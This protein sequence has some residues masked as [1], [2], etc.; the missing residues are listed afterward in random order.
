M[1]K[2][3]YTLTK[4]GIVYGNLVICAAGFFLASKG[5]INFWLLF[6]VIFGTALVIASGCVFNNLTDREIDTLMSRTRHRALVNKT[7][8]TQAA[9]FFGSCLGIIGFLTLIL[10]T[11]LL[12]VGVGLF[13]FLFYVVV[14]RIWKR[15]SVYGTLIGSVSGATP[16]V[17]GYLAVTNQLDIAALLL[18][19]ILV[20]WQMPHFFAI[21]IYR[22]DDYR[23]A[24][25][26]VLPAISGIFATKIQI[27]FF[28]VA[29]CASLPLLT[30]LGYTGYTYLIVTTIVSTAWLRLSIQ[31]FQTKNDKSWARKTFLFSQVVIVSLSIIL[32]LDAV[33]P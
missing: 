13:G 21:A 22:L 20:L 16:P 25:I 27:L 11:N 23:A 14:Y 3:Y 10:Y 6:A 4:P 19:L 15:A 18:F 2:T 1:V 24:K 7:V 12:T 26:P 31:G 9:I 29:F 28:M 8:S 5:S 17:A 33:L 32:S 30:I